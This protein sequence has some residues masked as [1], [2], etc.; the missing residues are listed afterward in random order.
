MTNKISLPV[1]LNNAATSFPK[2]PGIEKEVAAS[3]FKIPR[4]PGRSAFDESNDSLKLCRKAIAD[5]I[6]TQDIN[7]IVL[8]KNATEALNIVIN[9]I[10]IKNNTTVLTTAMEHNSVLRPLYYLQKRKNIRLIIIPCNSE[11][12][13]VKN[14]WIDAINNNNPD[15]VILNHASNVTGAVNDVNF[16]FNYAKKNECLTILDSSQTIGLINVNISDIMADIIVFTGH[17]Y[18]LGPTGTG[19]VYISKDVL[20]EPFFVGGTGIR[21]DLKEMPPEMPGKLEP[22]TPCSPLFAGLLKSIEWQKE[23]P[24]NFNKMNI[25]LERL[26]EGLT[27]IGVDVINVSGKKTGIVSFNLKNWSLEE[28]GFILDRSFSIICR[29]GLHCAPLIHQYIGTYPKGSVRLSLSRFTTEEEID[30]TI[31]SIRKFINENN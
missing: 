31:S 2:A 19:G 7:Q 1:Y 28:T 25:Q 30:Y 17:K 26:I 12:R 29:T 16:L 23:N 14:R 6:H 11:G 18:L 9:G 15:I 22:G 3:F 8:S 10:K 21:S 4:H 24:I 20:V 13:V 27:E 5:L